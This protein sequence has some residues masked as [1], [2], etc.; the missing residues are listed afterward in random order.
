M[1]QTID[2]GTRLEPIVDRYLIDRLDGTRLALQQPRDEGPV[3]RRDR[4]WEG[5][6]GYFTV[7]K[8]GDTY[9]AYYRGKS[10]DGP[11]GGTG[12]EHLLRRVD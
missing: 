7:L 9:R 6:I 1:S 5:M 4:P 8:D 11:D 3:L 12:R 10:G 2:I